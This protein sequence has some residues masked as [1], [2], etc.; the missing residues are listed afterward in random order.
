MLSNKLFI[1]ISVIT[2]SCTEQNNN[3]DTINISESITNDAKNIPDAIK[4]IPVGIYVINEPDTIY[5]ELN[6]KPESKY[7]WKHTTTLKALKNDLKIIEF[8]TYNFKNSKW[9]LGNYTKKPF[10]IE[11]FDKWYC[12]I[13]NGLITFD[14]CKNGKII[15]G[16]E[17]ID[18]S[19]YSIRNDTLVNRNG[20]WYYI[21]IDTTGKK[22]MGYGRY[23]T[24]NKLKV[25]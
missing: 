21:G 17:Y 13:K 22:F 25:N 11:N 12:L 2:I 24:I 3:V 20:L 19:N 5:A 16:Q 4:D 9:V 10:T 1:L 14:F 6:K 23:A 8:G 15:K 7:I 18:A